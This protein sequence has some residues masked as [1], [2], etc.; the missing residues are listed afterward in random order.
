MVHKE[1]TEN[2]VIGSCNIT[3]DEL[4]HSK[5]IELKNMNTNNVSGQLILEFMEGVETVAFL[6]Y[7]KSGWGMSLLCAIDYTASNKPFNDP[8]S[9]HNVS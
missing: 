5:Q 1:G 2:I 6:D 7:L 3:L 9:L 4:E 8:R